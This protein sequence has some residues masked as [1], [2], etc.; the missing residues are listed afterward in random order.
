MHACKNIFQMIIELFSI[1]VSAP[2][3][4]PKTQASCNLLAL[5]SQQ[6]ILESPNP[7]KIRD[8]CPHH[9]SAY[10]SSRQ[11]VP[12]ASKTSFG[13]SATVAISIRLICKHSLHSHCL[14]YIL[15]AFINSIMIISLRSVS[16]GRLSEQP[17]RITLGGQPYQGSTDSLNT[18]RPMDTGS[19]YYTNTI[20]HLL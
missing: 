1:Q 7:T 8:L 18:E 2:F 10:P 16:A 3:K 4:I 11:S 9:C 14:H 17:V 5:G 12:E 20:N 19:H 13:R 15:N 6:G